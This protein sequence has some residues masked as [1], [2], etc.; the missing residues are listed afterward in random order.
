MQFPQEEHSPEQLAQQVERPWGHHSVNI[1]GTSLPIGSVLGM[2]S[3][4]VDWA[5]WV[6]YLFLIPW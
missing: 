1:I 5:A 6:P 3:L 2:G 4:A